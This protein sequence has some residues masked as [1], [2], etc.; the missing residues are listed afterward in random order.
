MNG[1]KLSRRSWRGIILILAL[2]LSVWYYRYTW[3]LNKDEGI[4]DV[5]QIA[6]SVEATLPKEDI[7]I[8]LDNQLNPDH[9]LLNRLQNTLISVITVNP[10]ARY[11]YIYTEQNGKT[12]ILADSKSGH[13]REY[14]PPG[15]EYIK[16]DF[17][18]QQAI[19]EGKEYVTHLATRKYGRW[20][21]VFIPIKDETTSKTIAALGMDFNA[22]TWN[23]RLIYEMA[24][25]SVLIIL[26]LSAVFT[27]SKIDIK[28]HSLRLEIAER[29]QAEKDLKESESRFRSLF[30][31]MVEGFAYC[32]MIYNNGNPIDF[33]YL[34]TNESFEK[35]TGLKDVT[36][37]MVS[38][39]IPGIQQTDPGLF[40]TYHRVASTGNPER[41]ELFLEALK[42]WFQIS[43]YS[44]EKEYFVSI[45]DVI[46]ERK[47]AEE[48][49]KNYGL[50]LEETVKSRT[51]ELEKAKEKAES[52]DRVKSA[53]LANM[54]HEL[55]TPLNSII[56]FSGILLKEIPGPLTADQKKQ[57]EIVQLAGRNL[58]SMINDILDIS[59]IEAGQMIMIPET[60]ILEELIE[61]AMTIEWPAAKDKGLV[62]NFNKQSEIGEIVSDRKRLLQ[63]L[64]NLLDNAIKF[65]DEGSVSIECHKENDHVNIQ[66]SDTGIGIKQEDLE[67]IFTPFIQVN[68]ELTRE[69]RGTGL[70][71]PISKKL[72]T[73]L[74]GSITVKSEFG[75][76]SR[77]TIRLP[78]TYMPES[79]SD[80]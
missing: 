24:E 44:P 70:G 74:N 64:L 54:S 18:Y 67:E 12:D 72:I 29:K 61:E 42:M 60:F 77:F 80:K 36:G 19:R 57:L 6:R 68:N 15:Q 58:L 69:H 39:V 28:N 48:K 7:K 1:I 49:L 9:Q 66:L 3:K 34:E 43:V 35:L 65:T 63:V 22:I 55:R 33:I 26:L 2:I 32:K 71:L 59:K 30:E 4:N 75:K 17:A 78:L 47:L 53:F 5:L 50:H 20:L 23:Q 27:L 41:F 13:L 40:E 45:F 56:G 31:N 46:T 37:K 62:L 52:A 16:A 38:E 10:Q 76:G 14:A 21:S 11:A 73:L 8:L 51:I 79:K 25:S